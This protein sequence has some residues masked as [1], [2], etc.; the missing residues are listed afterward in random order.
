MGGRVYKTVDDV[1]EIL[2]NIYIHIYLV[3]RSTTYNS[4]S[5]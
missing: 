1:A 5:V 2:V 3:D 4:I